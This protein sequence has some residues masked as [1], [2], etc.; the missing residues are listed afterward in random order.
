LRI[1]AAREDTSFAALVRRILAERADA[2]AQ[3]GTEEP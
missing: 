1:A 3:A 2:L